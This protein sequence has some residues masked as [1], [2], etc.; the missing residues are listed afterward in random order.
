MFCPNCGNKVQSSDNYCS[1]CGTSLKN[2]KIQIIENNTSEQETRTFKPLTNLSGIDST[3]ELKDIIKA[4]DEKISKNISDYQKQS[5]ILKGSEKPSKENKKEVKDLSLTNELNFKKE[6]LDAS[7][8]E[9]PLKTQKTTKSTP[10]STPNKKSFREKFRDFINEDDDQFSIFSS[11]KDDTENLDKVELTKPEVKTFENTMDIPPINVIEE[12]LSKTNKKD[13]TNKEFDKKISSYDYKSFTELV[14]AELEKSKS[15]VKNEPSNKKDKA[16]EKTK[17]DSKTKSSDKKQ[18]VKKETEPV[19]EKKL[20]KSSEKSV[21]KEKFIDKFKNKFTNK[22]KPKE[23]LNK[24]KKDNPF[25]LSKANISKDHHTL[26]DISET[27]K[28]NLVFQKLRSIHTI[29]TKLNEKQLLIFAI[30]LSIIPV[31]I[32]VVKWNNFSLIIVFSLVIKILIKLAQFYIPLNLATEKAWI[33]SS[34]SEIKHFA[35]INY[36][37]SEIIML[38]MFIFSPWYGI[39]Y[40]KTLSAFTA[41]PVA[42]IVLVLF[43]T[44]LS[45]S[46]FH[47]QLKETNKIDFIGWYMILFIISEFIG[48]IIFM[49]TDILV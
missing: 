38:V 3:S 22:D 15:D 30:L 4:V 29:A 9:E 20:E 27:M 33:D 25:K 21:T 13:T 16:D 43:A 1:N 17:K 19:K 23:N 44:C 39:F 45:V 41:F 42:T 34:Y 10:K 12:E 11:L 28:T 7:T 31:V 32:S 5:S 46:Q 26:E 24:E 37:L 18:T 35:L 49:F 40:F 14:N 48:K 2:V 8:K 36:F 6:N 47:N